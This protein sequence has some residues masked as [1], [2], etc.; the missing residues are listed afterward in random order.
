MHSI[1]KPLGIL[2][3]II[4]ASCKTPKVQQP[5]PNNEILNRIINKDDTITIDEFIGANAFVDDPI[6]N[7]TAVGFIREYHNW[8]WDEGDGDRDY[9]G[10]PNNQIRF[11]PS[12]PG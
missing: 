1:I 4:F 9:P 3:L 6:E 8:A 11:A 10:F 5:I 12:N 7:L 2:I